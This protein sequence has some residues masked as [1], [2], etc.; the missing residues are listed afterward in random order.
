MAEAFFN[1]AAK[2]RG[3]DARAESAGTMGGG[4]INP[5]VAEAMA[6]VGVPLT[7]HFPKQLTQ[8][9]VD[10]ADRVVSMGCGVDAEACP[11]K[12]LVTEDWGLDDPKGLDLETVRPIR[13]AI[14]KRVANL[15]R[16]C[17]DSD[18]L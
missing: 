12:F 9:M 16:E 13:D 1:H 15:L 17:A 10:R 2:E 7:G 11:A 5:V 4:E 6:E 14:R 3:V 18:A 8:E